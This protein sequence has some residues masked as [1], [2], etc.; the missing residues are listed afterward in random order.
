MKRMSN[1]TACTVELW[2]R[3]K[4]CVVLA[5]SM[6]HTFYKSTLALLTDIEFDYAIMLGMLQYSINVIE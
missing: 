6:E 5:C 2:A 3:S 4:T 1:D